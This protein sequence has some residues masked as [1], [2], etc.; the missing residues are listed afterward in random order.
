MSPIQPKE[1]STRSVKKQ[2][3][4]GFQGGRHHA[5]RSI[6]VTDTFGM[7]VSYSQHYTDVPKGIDVG[8][9]VLERVVNL[10]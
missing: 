10:L 6:W 9:Q 4:G 8:E 7:H 2:Y 5:N 1:C 3:N